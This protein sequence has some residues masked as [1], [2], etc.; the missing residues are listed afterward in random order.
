MGL[1]QLRHTDA[2]THRHAETDTHSKTKNYRHTD[3]DTLLNTHMFFS[4]ILQSTITMG[5]R[6]FHKY[7]VIWLSNNGFLIKLV[8]YQCAT[9]ENGPLFS[10]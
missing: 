7:L 10:F 9:N 6:Y 5:F 2:Q 1:Y 3:K 8:E 4:K